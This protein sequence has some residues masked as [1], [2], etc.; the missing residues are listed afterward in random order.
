[1]HVCNAGELNQRAV[2][3]ECGGNF[4]DLRKAFFTLTGEEAPLVARVGHATWWLCF[5]GLKGEKHLKLG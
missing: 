1:M 2:E 4:V 3:E 5:G